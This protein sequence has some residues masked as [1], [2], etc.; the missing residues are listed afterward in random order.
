MKKIIS[1][2][3]ALIMVMGCLSS[4][5]VCASAAGAPEE[6]N[7]FKFALLTFI[8]GEDG[9][10]AYIDATNV[11]TM[12][13]Y[14]VKVGSRL[15]DV[16]SFPSAVTSFSID[17]STDYNAVLRNG[18]LLTV[19]DEN[20]DDYNFRFIIYGDIDCDGAVDVLDSAMAETVTSGSQT[21]QQVV[22]KIK[23]TTKKACVEKAIDINKDGEFTSDDFQQSVNIS[24]DTESFDQ[25]R[26]NAEEAN[27]VIPDV[28]TQLFTGNSIE[29]VSSVEFNNLVLSIGND[30]D[31]NY[32]ENIEKGV[33]TVTITGKGLY[34]GT[35]VKNFRITDT[36]GKAA[37][38]LNGVLTDCGLGK[39]LT[40]TYDDV[41]KAF[42]VNV[43][44]DA[45]LAGNFSVDSTALTGMLSRI[46]NYVKTSLASITDVTVEGNCVYN[47]E[48]VN[49]TALKNTL[50][51]LANG[52]FVNVAGMDE[53]GVIKTVQGSFT[54]N[55]VKTD[56]TASF[57][58]S[59]TTEN[60]AT[61]KR[62]AT[63]FANHMSFEVVG[64]NAV[65]TAKIPQGFMNT[66][67]DS[68]GDGD[69]AETKRQFDTL[70]VKSAFSILSD[71]TAEDFSSSTA[72]FSKVIDA[73]A[74]LDGFINKILTKITSAKI[75]DTKGRTYTAMSDNDFIV[76]D[77]NANTFGA[78]AGAVGNKLSNEVR[79]TKTGDYYLGNGIYQIAF[80]LVVDVSN[81]G[82]MSN[83][84]ISERVII[85]LD[86]FR[87]LTGF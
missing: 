81:L 17:G 46:G 53:N 22:A 56:F 86:I 59:G 18:S 79:A 57:T 25:T 34:T 49:N 28:D 69:V 65:I 30:Y 42:N 31:I 78:F 76:D 11:K 70:S 16:V 64:G 39:V 23:N 74:S 51:S 29:P 10:S 4:V 6:S 15:S 7:S 47:G 80:D 67:V 32:S 71:V 87:L 36:V 40:V 1:L 61:L 41:A 68:I 26:K 84:A 33:A 14:G 82:L 73:V 12:Y 62:I 20:D 85:Q 60:I 13:I 83:G 45:L 3:L 43:N 37:A 5:S 38:D 8:P 21:V 55:E 75:T 35:V 27:T 24:V 19:T 77:T 48:T 63:K 50:F 2:A 58:A 9:K 44:S 54:E 66:L 72:D 52:F